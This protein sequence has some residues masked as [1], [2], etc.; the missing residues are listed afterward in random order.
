MPSFPPQI[1]IQHLQCTQ[2]RAPAR[3]ASEENSFAHPTPPH[4]TPAA[5]GTPPLPSP[6]SYSCRGVSDL[7]ASAEVESLD[8]TPQCVPP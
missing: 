7:E 4:P 3:V 6:L 8:D 2:Q 1:F 5:V